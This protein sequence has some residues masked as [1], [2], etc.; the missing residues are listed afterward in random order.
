[1]HQHEWME[2]SKMG[3]NKKGALVVEV[4]LLCYTCNQVIKVDMLIKC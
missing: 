2:E 1:M 4:V 3:T